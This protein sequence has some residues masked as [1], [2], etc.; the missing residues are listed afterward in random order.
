MGPIKDQLGLEQGGPNSSEEYK[1][2]NN[3]LLSQAQDSRLGVDMGGSLVVSAIGQADDTVLLS[4]NI[5][6]L[7][8][9]LQLTMD[10]CSKFNVKPRHD[11]FA[12]HHEAELSPS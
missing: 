7:K 12:H 3:E 1:I 4:N 6:K 9:I 10:Y 5:I 11:P 2:Y 8:L